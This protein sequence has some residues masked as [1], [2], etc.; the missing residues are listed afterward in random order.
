M[1]KPGF[2]AGVTSAFRGL[3][4]A[5]TT[6]DVGKTYLQLAG[7]M[8]ILVL[9]LDVVGI[10]TI[11]HFT[12]MTP[13][14]AWYAT[15]GMWLLRIA[16]IAIVLLAA[17]AIAMFI[18]TTV[19]PVLGERVF[20]AGMGAVDPERAAELAAMDGLPLRSAVAQNLI[21][22]FMFIGLSIVAF[23]FSFVPVI[24]SIGGPVLQAYFTARALGW[25]L[26]DPYFEKL[27]MRFDAQHEYVKAHR[28][29]LVGFA[30][31][32]SFVMAIPLL[33]PFA[34]GLAQAAAGVFARELLEQAEPAPTVS[35]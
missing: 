32:Y 35:E 28:A 10:C 11:L 9:A 3:K 18:T 7:V 13:D 8:F 19:F 17:P 5:M 15:V 12:G 29:P 25:E 33:G 21:R 26:L 34:F 14:Q 6:P 24:G 23:A 20:L 27:Q 1:K 16:G 2:V 4:I 30:L 22:M 31:P